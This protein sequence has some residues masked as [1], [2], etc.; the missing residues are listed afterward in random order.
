MPWGRIGASIVRPYHWLLVLL[1]SSCASRAP[2]LYES[3]G[4]QLARMPETG[5]TK[6]DVSM[7]LGQ[8]PERCEATAEAAPVIGVTVALQD[9]VVLK[10]VPGGPATN[11]GLTVGEV[12]RDVNGSPVRTGQEV[13]N[14]VRATTEAG[15][16]FLLRTDRGTYELTP[17]GVEAEQCYWALDAGQVAKTGSSA[18]VNEYGG[19][20][21]SSG[22]AYS[23]FFRASCRFHGDAVAV[24]QAN[25]QE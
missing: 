23:R 6:A 5:A 9:P 8:P 16:P 2:S 18:W 25:W 22:S 7:L 20:A 10:I 21:G 3:W 14:V 19:A 12:I 11:S 24:C 15:E 4:Q 1:L 13:I 17:E